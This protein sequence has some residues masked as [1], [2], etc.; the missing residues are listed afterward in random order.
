MGIG[1][2]HYL[3]ERAGVIWDKS[4]KIF[5]LFGWATNFFGSVGPPSKIQSLFVV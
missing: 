1:H 5:Q 2:K 4:W 3:P